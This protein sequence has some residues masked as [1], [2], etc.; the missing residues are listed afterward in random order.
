[1]V[2]GETERL[3]LRHWKVSDI[4]AFTDLLTDERIRKFLGFGQN[5]TPEAVQNELERRIF[6]CKERGWGS[7][8]VVDR[9][10]ELVVGSCG[11]GQ[12]TFPIST[13]A[14]VFHHFS[15]VVK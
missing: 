13:P 10:T 3:I 4:A 12:H 14:V 8:A 6:E 9:T 7:W 5:V 1:M 2:V 15:E 11:F